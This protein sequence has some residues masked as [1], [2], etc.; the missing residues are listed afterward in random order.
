MQISQVLVCGHARSR[1]LFFYVNTLLARS[2]GQDNNFTMTLHKPADVTDG[3][4]LKITKEDL[5]IAQKQQL[6]KAIEDYKQACL[7]AFSD[8]KRGEAI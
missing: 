1:L 2:V 8:T 3:N 4:I 6:D 5:N 7:G